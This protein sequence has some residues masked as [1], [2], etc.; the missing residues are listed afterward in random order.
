[1]IFGLENMFIERWRRDK[2]LLYKVATSHKNLNYENNIISTHPIY[3][4]R[5]KYVF[6]INSINNKKTP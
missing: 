6:P 3:K 4:H 5:N 1:M 2:L